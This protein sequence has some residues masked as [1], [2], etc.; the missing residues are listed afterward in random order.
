M[1]QRRYLPSRCHPADRSSFLECA[2]HRP[3]LRDT[4]PQRGRIDDGYREDQHASLSVLP[5][6]MANQ[7]ER[8][9]AVKRLESEH[10]DDMLIMVRK[11]TACSSAELIHIELSARQVSRQPMFP[12]TDVYYAQ[13]GLSWDPLEFLHTGRPCADCST[14]HREIFAIPRQTAS[15][16]RSEYEAVVRPLILRWQRFVDEIAP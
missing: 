16:G 4:F 2:S 10:L 1:S 13:D 8:C 11:L 15:A 9:N 7:G 14:T 6:A 3:T 12:S 5:G